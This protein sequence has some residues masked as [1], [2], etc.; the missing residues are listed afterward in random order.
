LVVDTPANSDTLSATTIADLVCAVT[1]L[2]DAALGKYQ[3][4][5]SELWPVVA[6]RPIRSHECPLESVTDVIWL[7]SPVYTLADNTRR[8][9]ALVWLENRAVKDVAADCSWAPTT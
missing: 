9:P 5:P 3:S 7:V 4:S 2:T 1:A 8:F 6:Y